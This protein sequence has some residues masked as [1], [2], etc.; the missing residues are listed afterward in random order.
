MAAAGAAMYAFERA[1]DVLHQITQERLPPA[2]ASLELSRQAE[3][4][5]AAAPALLSA[6]TQQ[7]RELT[8]DR[9]AIELA[10]MVGLLDQIRGA[11]DQTSQLISVR[12]APLVL[13]FEGN[14]DDLNFIVEGRLRLVERRRELLKR[15]TETLRASRRL[16]APGALLI[17]STLETWVNN[18]R[19][20]APAAPLSGEA[21]RQ[22][23]ETLSP[24][25]PQRNAEVVLSDI[26]DSFLQIA[27][28]ENVADLEVRAA[29]IARSIDSL[30]NVAAALSGEIQTDMNR[31]VAEFEGLFA[32]DDALLEIRRREFEGVGRAERVLADNA[33][34][35][36]QFT[37]A[38]N[39]L[40][41][42]SKEDID[43]ANADAL[44][45]Q[46][47]S[48]A[49]LITLVAMSLV[50]S[51]LIAWLY[52]DR[53][54]VA[55]LRALS[56][57]MLA[58]AGGNLRAPLPQ[59]QARDEIGK[60][61]EAL[62]VFRDTATEV[63]ENNL[64]DIAKARTR[65]VNA[66]ECTSEGFAFFDAEDRLEL[67]NARYR[68]LLRAGEEIR[69]GTP[70]EALLRG[71]VARGAIDSAQIDPERWIE[72]RLAR[73]RN[74]AEP[75]V[76]RR[77]DGRWIMIS[78]RQTEGGGIVSVYS[79]ITELKQRE[80]EV[81]EKS[82]L[83]E[84]TLEHM[85]QGI[86]MFDRE[87]RLTV[88]N[89][90]F[91]ELL[92][93][94]PELFKP[95]NPLEAM[96]RFNAERGEFGPGDVEEQVQARIE[97]ALR[98][99]PHHFERVRPDGTV[100]AVDGRPLPGN[101]GFVS[102]Y[103]DVTEQRRKEAQVEAANAEIARKNQELE[104]LS[105]KLA[106]YLSPQVYASIFSGQQEVKIASVRKEL[107]VFFSDIVDFTETTD[108]VESEVLTQLL[109]RYL[110]EMSQ[111]AL[112]HGAT[113]DKY[114]GDAIVIFFGDPESRGVK[115]DALACVKMAI[116]MRARMRELAGVWREMGVEQPLRCRI[117]ISTG[118]CTVG[119]FGSE[120]RMDYTI[121]GGG[122]NLAARLE[123]AAT[124]G[125]ILIGYETYT[126][127]KDEIYC[128]ERGQI[129]IKGI[130]YPVST[131]EVID[132]HANFQ[133]GLQVIHEERPHVTIDLDLAAMSAEERRDAAQLLESVRDRIA[134][135]G[136]ARHSS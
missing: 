32:G 126:L 22:L 43:Q 133:Q 48:S 21:A 45:A 76:Q 111:V 129:R 16:V 108:R 109:N 107:T 41:A 6:S 102:T 97:L 66:L 11:S 100:L 90:R 50:S 25:L 70:F 99:E 5:V 117:G 115:E 81:A 116:A 54:L 42:T 118:Y 36:Q 23:I 75:L 68:E 127:V 85:N 98:F 105:S 86:T 17:D 30:K 73:H 49:I 64:R 120:D 35:A 130:A 119:N 26:N 124:S 110:T 44:R 112:D 74:P 63:E 57:S 14:L 103:T 93:F 132:L 91:M 53:N 89:R 9:I 47:F 60:M 122:V 29:P 10:D 51:G 114:V 55:R 40:V 84:L 136:T 37:A 79:D 4:I 87:L 46:R 94:P 69:H 39:Q 28:A 92:D 13:G 125:S 123:H 65:L 80:A 61:G 38:V 134:G 83:L 62:A 78:E 2:L 12:A 128:Q 18:A 7:E 27:M 77:S 82:Q 67:S 33:E 96:F 101:A 113:I 24:L 52:V 56:D 71:S 104:S 1:G 121:I 88:F 8:F 135:R 95:G 19:R 106:K 20:T 31:H 34:L 15:F 58:I 131:Y 3:R 72:E 59:V